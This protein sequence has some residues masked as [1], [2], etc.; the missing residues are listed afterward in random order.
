[1]LRQ[2]HWRSVASVSLQI[3]ALALLSLAFFM[4]TPQ[5]SG[6]SMAPHIA[7]G[8]FV[9]INTVTYRMQFPQ[10]GDIIAFRHDAPGPE[11]LI[12]RVIGTPG[13]RIAVLHGRVLVNGRALKEPYVRYP[14]DRSFLE[15]TVPAGALYVLGDNRANSDDSRF[16]GFV[17]LDHVIGKALAGI[18]P[19]GHLGSL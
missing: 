3:A 17:P 12:K 8:E 16:W 19:L 9:L 11:S 10:R 7:S 18:W 5:V 15:V 13:D 6:L 14:D 1:M 4:R 2:M